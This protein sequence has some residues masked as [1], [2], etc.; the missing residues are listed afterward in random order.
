MNEMFSNFTLQV[1]IQSLVVGY[2]GIMEERKDETVKQEKLRPQN[3]LP[4][5]TSMFFRSFNAIQIIKT[6]ISMTMTMTHE[7]VDAQC[8]V[9][10]V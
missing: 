1:I 10:F 5:H 3:Q 8:L 6:F 7:Q 2:R 9:V 4:S